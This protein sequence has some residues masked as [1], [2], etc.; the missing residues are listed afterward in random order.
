MGKGR[1]R[2][3]NGYEGHVLMSERVSVK[4]GFSPLEG[5]G[6]RESNTA[7]RRVWRVDIPCKLK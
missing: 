2:E 1:E 3:L 6:G 4:P 5:R 7:S